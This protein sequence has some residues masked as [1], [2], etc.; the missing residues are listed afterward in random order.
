M[1]GG[2]A[3]YEAISHGV[4]HMLEASFL[5]G[6]LSEK[7]ESDSYYIEG[8]NHFSNLKTITLNYYVGNTFFPGKRFQL[9]IYAGIGANYIMA[10]PIKSLAL[11]VGLKARAKFYITDR[12]GIF[13]GAGC[14]YGLGSVRYGSNGKAS[15]GER[16]LNVEAGLT[17]SL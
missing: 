14:R 10:D 6:N 16:I 5:T 11:N 2:F 9:P 7:K 13:A 17:F 1:F 15:L 8:W 12:F 3:F 4:T